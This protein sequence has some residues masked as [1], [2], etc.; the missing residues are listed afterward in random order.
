M[1]GSSGYAHMAFPV[2]YQMRLA[3]LISIT[4]G[5]RDVT[6]ADEVCYGEPGHAGSANA[7]ASSQPGDSARVP[8]MCDYMLAFP[9]TCSSA[10]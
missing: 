10:G 5:V 8:G 1:P 3:D 4:K 7:A 2:S 6:A 9:V